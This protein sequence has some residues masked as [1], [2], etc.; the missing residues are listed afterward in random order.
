MNVTAAEDAL[1]A[2][3]VAATGLAADRVVWAHQPVTERPSAYVTLRLLGLATVGHDGLTHSYDAGADA[4]EE[5]TIET[6]GRRVLSVSVQ[7]YSDATTGP[8]AAW[9][10]L[11]KAQA[12]LSLPGRRAALLAAGLASFGDASTLD[13]SAIRETRFQS[14][15]SLTIQFHAVDSATEKTTFVETAT[16]S[17]NWP[18]L[19]EAGDTLVTES[20]D[21]IALE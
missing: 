16:V 15:A 14:R 20:G 1:Y 6:E 13:L 11:A 7:A 4:G 18:L 17:A 12:A 19:T 2:W 3:L 10:M 21:T 5:I 8:T 9:A